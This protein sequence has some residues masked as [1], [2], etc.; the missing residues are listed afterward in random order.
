MNTLATIYFYGR[1][2]VKI[3]N[4]LNIIIDPEELSGNV[5]VACDEWFYVFWR[6]QP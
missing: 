4:K 1:L 3:S 5:L 6:S 2:A